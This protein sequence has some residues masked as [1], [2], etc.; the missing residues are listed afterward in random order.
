[1]RRSEIILFLSTTSIHGLNHLSLTKSNK[2]Q[3]FWLIITCGCFAAMIANM[4][5][6]VS[7]FISKP[8]SIEMKYQLDTG[9]YPSI[10]ICPSMFIPSP[11]LPKND[12]FGQKNTDE[13]ELEIIHYLRKETIEPLWTAIYQLQQENRSKTSQVNHKFLD[14]NFQFLREASN[15]NTLMKI[16]RHLNI[17]HQTRKDSYNMVVACEFSFEKCAFHN[18]QLRYHPVYKMCFTFQHSPD[19]KRLGYPEHLSLIA[20]GSNA[21]FNELLNSKS[22]S[23]FRGGL[24]EIHPYKTMPTMKYAHPFTQKS[25]QIVSITKYED[26]I[27]NSHLYQCNVNEYELYNRR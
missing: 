23:Q 11:E 8:I 17:S 3:T 26:R 12:Y 24:Y 25:R 16:L 2:H 6:I 1:M 4:E 21:G 9:E 18:F 22:I 19:N 10:T 13:K 27:I 7:T 20:L 14:S 15:K 5:K